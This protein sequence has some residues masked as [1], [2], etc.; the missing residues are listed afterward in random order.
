MAG[1]CEGGNE[2]PGSLKVS[3]NLGGIALLLPRAPF[4]LQSASWSSGRMF[5]YDCFVRNGESVTVVRR[6]F[7]YRFSINRNDSVPARVYED[8]PRILDEL[9]DEIRQYITQINRDLLERVQVNFRQ[10]LQQYV[11]ADGHHMPDVIFRS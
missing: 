3:A 7:C 2:T 11:I 4:H 9:K 8:K 1:L 6:E 5:A 10:R